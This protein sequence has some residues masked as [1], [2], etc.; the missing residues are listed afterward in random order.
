VL[1]VR[2]RRAFLATAILGVLTFAAP[3]RTGGQ[4]Q[5]EG[6]GS[7]FSVDLAR[8]RVTLDH[9][10][11]GGV[12]PAMRMEFAVEA[13]GGVAALAP[14]DVVRFTL[15]SQGPEWVIASIAKVAAPSP[16]AP[17]GF[18]APD[19]S[20]PVLGGEPLRLSSQRGKAVLLNF[21]ATWCAPCR[22][23]MPALERLYQRHK[24]A[25]LEVI[26]INLNTPSAAGV[27]AF[28]QEVKVTFP[29][30]LDPGW[31]TAQAYRV[32][33][34]PTTYLIDRTGHVVVRELGA[35][36]WDDQ[37]SHAAVTKLLE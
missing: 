25:G 36:D 20:L 3:P 18:P 1:R 11:I 37:P 22:T 14:G 5:P 21:W 17:V 15:R 19:F 24:A 12:M 35:R 28:V 7:V 31:S 6:L 27:E 23:E 30:A 26:A 2:A 16:A 34:L 33:G 8:G 9:G 4:A 10:P 32:L 13:E 29:I